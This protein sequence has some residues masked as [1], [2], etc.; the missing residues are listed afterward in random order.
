MSTL[1]NRKLSRA[2]SLA[3]MCSSVILVGCNDGDNGNVRPSAA[4]ANNPPNPV[5]RTLSGGPSALNS[6]INTV[7]GLTNGVL[8]PVTSALNPV[9]TP[10]GVAIDPLLNPVLSGLQPIVSPLVSTISRLP[11]LWHL[12]LTVYCP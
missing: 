6:T 2:V 5:I 1:S 10:L 12:L 8:T 4:N 11:Q 9:I 7:N 3:V